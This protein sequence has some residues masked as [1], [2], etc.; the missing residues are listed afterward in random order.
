MGG[1]SSSVSLSVEQTLPGCD[2]VFSF[3]G[4]AA[5]ELKHNKTFTSTVCLVK[6]IKVCCQMPGLAFELLQVQKKV[7]HREEQEPLSKASLPS[8]ILGDH[9]SAGL[10]IAATGVT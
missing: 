2:I 10:N 1:A 9:M 5:I 7:Y 3:L 6:Q 4:C 8:W